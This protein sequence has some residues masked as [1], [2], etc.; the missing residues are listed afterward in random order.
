[1]ASH[2]QDDMM[3]EYS[4][5]S[6][7]DY[8]N[9]PQSSMDS[10]EG[11]GHHVN[12]IYPPPPPNGPPS[13]TITRRWRS[14][15]NAQQ[16]FGYIGSIPFTLE[17]AQMSPSAVGLKQ[18]TA[19]PTYPAPFPSGVAQ[20]P[21]TEAGGCGGDGNDGRYNAE[22]AAVRDVRLGNFSTFGEVRPY[23]EGA[24]DDDS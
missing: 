22:D 10:N 8:P 3:D 16:S 7:E 19:Y 11:S 12:L 2:P 20:P 15:Q 6:Y 21:N 9:Y 18:A 1:M 5:D 24:L 17:P 13:Q 23:F 4:Y 14:P